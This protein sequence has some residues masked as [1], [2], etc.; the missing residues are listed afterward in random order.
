MTAG[1]RDGCAVKCSIEADRF[2]INGG[3]NGV[4]E[5]TGTG[6]TGIGNCGALEILERAKG[7]KSN[8]GEVTMGGLH[9]GAEDDF[10][11][12]NNQPKFLNCS[13]YQHQ[14]GASLFKIEVQTAVMRH[15]RCESVSK[16]MT[17]FVSSCRG[18]SVDAAIF[19][20][21]VSYLPVLDYIGKNADSAL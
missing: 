18:G 10:R 1:Q 9:F 19:G 17:T 7:S 12:S 16:M 11:N 5:R 14:C 6:I 2:S 3:G 21:I 4:A 20:I 13:Y 15:W 8:K